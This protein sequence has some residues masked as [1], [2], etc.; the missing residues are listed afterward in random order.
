MKREVF[1]NYINRFNKRD[2][3]ALEDAAKQLLV[4]HE[5]HQT[6]HGALL[7]SHSSSR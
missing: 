7:E 5:R 4:G 3:T 6:F 2:A 1:D